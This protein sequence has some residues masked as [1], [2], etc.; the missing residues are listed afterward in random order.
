V[1]LE[2]EVR[3]LERWTTESVLVEPRAFESPFDPC[4]DELDTA[5]GDTFILHVTDEKEGWDCRWGCG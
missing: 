5:P 2:L 4:P 1:G 3:V